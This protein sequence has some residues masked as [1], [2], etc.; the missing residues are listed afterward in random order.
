MVPTLLAKYPTDAMKNFDGV[1]KSEF[2]FFLFLIFN[3]TRHLVGIDTDLST[4]L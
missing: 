4:A 1:I 3:V 2:N